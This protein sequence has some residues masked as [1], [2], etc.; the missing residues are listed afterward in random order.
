M[1]TPVPNLTDVCTLLQV[2]DMFESMRFYERHLGFV[3]EQQAPL[4]EQPY[5]HINWAM[6]VRD[7]M[8]LML[9]TAYEADERPALRDPRWVAGHRD[10]CLYFSCPDVDG[11]YAILREQGLDVKPP[12]VASYGMKQLYFSDPDGYVICLQWPA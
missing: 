3:V 10:V 2:F 11:A 8:S 5:P 7:D 9:N 6:L 12:T 4:V 1:M